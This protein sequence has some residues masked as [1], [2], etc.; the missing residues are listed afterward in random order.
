VTGTT[1][2][3]LVKTTKT[4]RL[5]I[6]ISGGRRRS[7]RCAVDRQAELRP[8]SGHVEELKGFAIDDRRP[9]SDI[10]EDLVASW[11]KRRR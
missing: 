6:S 4:S 9:V 10:I 11:I 5:W 8:G 1:K 3:F 7:L 2:L